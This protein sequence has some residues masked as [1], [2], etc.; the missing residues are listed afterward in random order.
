MNDYIRGFDDGCHIVLGE[1]EQEH[2]RTG[3]KDILALLMHLRGQEIEKT[4]P[5]DDKAALML[6]IE[7]LHYFSERSKNAMARTMAED[8][9]LAGETLLAKIT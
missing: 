7:V 1:I 4:P 2:E 3:S 5:G 9:I 6:M 8:A